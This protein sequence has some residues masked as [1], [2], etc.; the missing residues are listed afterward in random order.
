MFVKIS[1]LV[2]LSFLL[3]ILYFDIMQGLMEGLE[4]KDWVKVCESLNDARRFA[5]YH[6]DLLFPIS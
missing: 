2:I 6:S 3:L 5:L 4:S 1:S